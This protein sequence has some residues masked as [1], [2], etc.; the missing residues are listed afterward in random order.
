[1]ADYVAQFYIE[2]RQIYNSQTLMKKQ[3]YL[4]M[5]EVTNS[6]NTLRKLLWQI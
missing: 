5:S 3:G 2:F 6:F 4:Y 1:M